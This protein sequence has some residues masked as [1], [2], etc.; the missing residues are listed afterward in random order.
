MQC[1]QLSVAIWLELGGEAS[2]RGPTGG[3]LRARKM[4]NGSSN[5]TPKPPAIPSVKDMIKIPKPVEEARETLAAKGIVDITGDSLKA[6]LT[7]GAYNKISN[8]FRM[9]MSTE[10]TWW[11]VKEVRSMG[12][13]T[14][15]VLQ[16]QPN[17]NSQ[18]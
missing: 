17:I 5:K 16:G 15:H 13:S 9:H 6:N 12:Q 7:P 11:A 2:L 1:K 8:N 18:T 3:A 4:V 10:K 14:T